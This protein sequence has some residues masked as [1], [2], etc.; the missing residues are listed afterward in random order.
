MCERVQFDL[1]R[2][3]AEHKQV[4]VRGPMK[5]LSSRWQKMAVHLNYRLSLLFG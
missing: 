5:L 3:E 1:S 4:D 2:A